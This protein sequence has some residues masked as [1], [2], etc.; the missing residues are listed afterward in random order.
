[1]A[2]PTFGTAHDLSGGLAAGPT[3][4]VL[5]WPTVFSYLRLATQS[6]IFRSPFSPA[7]AAA[8][9][10][11]LLRLPHVRAAGE[12][13]GFWDTYL[14]VTDAVARPSLRLCH[15]RAAR[16]TCRQKPR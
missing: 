4:V 7:E 11:A 12:Q 2:P 13:D 1:M 5:L 8:N 14:R 16:R 15:S 10:G 9:I 3:L 6:A